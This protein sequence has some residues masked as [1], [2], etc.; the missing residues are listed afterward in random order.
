VLFG[1]GFGKH[2]ILML[3]LTLIISGLLTGVI[4]HHHH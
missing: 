1:I 3:V 4:P 2:P